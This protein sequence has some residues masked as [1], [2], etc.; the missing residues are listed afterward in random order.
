MHHHTVE[1]S[2]TSPHDGTEPC[3]PPVGLTDEE[4]TAHGII[5]IQ[6]YARAS[7][8]PTGSAARSKRARERAAA[9]GAGQLN[10]TAPVVAHATLRAIAKDLQAGSA[11]CDVLRG[12]L[13][14]E[15]QRTSPSALVT[16]TTDRAA[17]KAPAI[18]Q[19]TNVLA[20]WK[21]WVTAWW[22]VGAKFFHR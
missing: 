22:A 20:A 12:A 11:L 14:A 19:K 21:I 10:V 5:K 1:A 17:A 8:N 13:T 15:A 6:A 16:V 7:S 4:L 3:C 2:P 18:R 9:S